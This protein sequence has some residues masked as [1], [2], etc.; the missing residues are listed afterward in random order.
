MSEGRFRA[1]ADSATGA[2][3]NILLTQ[4]A[5]A[6]GLQGKFDEAG[7]ILADLPAEP[8]ELAVRSVLEMGRVANSR[9]AKEAARTLFEEAFEAASAAG[10]EHLAVDALHMVAVVAP[11][12]EQEALNRRALELAAGA[13]DPRASDWRAS[14]LNNLGWAIFER[15][16]YEAALGAFEDALVARIEQGKSGNIQVARWCVGRT[17]RALGRI[18]EAQA[19]QQALAAEHAAAGTSDPYV[20]EELT[21]LKSVFKIGSPQSLE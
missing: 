20:Q 15:G 6:L 1:A 13:D 3:R 9:G 5:R 2:D 7:E 21:E 11:A 18:E 19:I 14:L 8:L 12:S 4:V 10:F 17:L 16:D